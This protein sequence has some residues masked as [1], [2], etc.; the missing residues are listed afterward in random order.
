MIMQPKS[1][2]IRSK[3][4]KNPRLEALI[5]QWKKGEKDR[6]RGHRETGK[7]KK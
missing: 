6:W 2:Q 5:S 1:G 3:T 7:K 4:E